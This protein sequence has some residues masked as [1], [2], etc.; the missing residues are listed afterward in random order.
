MKIFFL[1][2]SFLSLFIFSGC[3]T[4]KVFEPSHVDSDWSRYGDIN[5]SILDGVPSAAVLENGQVLIKNKF[6]NVKVKKPYSIV[7]SSDG[8]IISSTI[9]GK[10]RLQ[11]ISNPKNIKNFDL[12]R[13]IATASINNNILAILFA[14]DEM[15]LYNISTKKLLLREQGSSALA[16]DSRIV[17]PYFMNGL[18]MFSTLDGKIVIINIK[19]KKKLRTVIVS[20]QEN[21]NNI[22]YFNIIDNKIIAATNTKILSLSTKEIRAKYEVR[23]IV[24][25]KNNIYVAT[26]NGSI[27]KLTP[28]LQENAKL[29]FPFA[30]F[31]GMI[32][33]N[34][35]LFIL[36]KEGYLIVTDKNLLHYTIN[37]INIDDNY[38]FI[39]KKKFYIADEFISVE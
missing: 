6:T 1:L 31:L 28:N 4:K 24:H 37:K 14:D 9:A 18:V 19:L 16:L 39:G 11:S 17:K 7:S 20:S 10:L 32:V 23:S 30:H 12:K 8:W 21:F 3:S 22:I 5:E 38:V 33:H 29:K 15:A 13:T 27:I 34:D 25:D 26:K 35:K 36:E 2:V